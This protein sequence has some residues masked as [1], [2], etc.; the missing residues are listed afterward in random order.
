MLNRG[1]IVFAENCAACHSSRQPDKDP[2]GP[3]GKITEE[4]KNWFR[5]KVMKPEFFIGNFLSDERRHP[6]T[7]IGTNATRAA[8]TNATRSHIWDN[9]SSETYKTL[10]AIGTFEVDNPP[11][12]GGKTK[13]SIPLPG[14]LP[15]PGYYRPPSLISL[16]SSAPYLHNNTVGVDPTAPPLRGKVDVPARMQAF[17]DGIEKMLWI[18]PRGTLVWKTSKKSYINVPVAYLPDF[19]QDVKRNHSELYDA[20][21]DSLRLGPIPAGTPVDG[22]RGA[23]RP[24]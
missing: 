23:R 19:L 13:I 21:T 17:Q 7:Q 4:A 14:E 20:A 12:L 3:D 9:F 16:W 11:D 2:F 15:G 22:S 24:L 10:P 6:V 8:A 1:K 18:K 5:T